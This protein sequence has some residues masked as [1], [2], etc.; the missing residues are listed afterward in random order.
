MK[1]RPLFAIAALA[2]AGCATVAKYDA[3]NDIHA[4]LVAVRDGDKAAFDAHVDKPALKAQLRARLIEEAASRHGV[5]S[6][7]TAGAI[8][9]G[10]MVDIAVEVLVRPEV[11]RAAASLLGYGPERPIPNMIAIGQQVK[12]LSNDRVCVTLGHTCTFIFKNEDGAW[13]LIAFEGD[14]DALL[15]HIKGPVRLIPAH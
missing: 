7:E 3:S 2:V 9:A 11:F 5:E 13:R 15:K 10:P 1:F 6:N 8:M 12:P 14:I 4:F